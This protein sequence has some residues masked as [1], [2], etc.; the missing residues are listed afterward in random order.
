MVIHSRTGRRTITYQTW[1]QGRDRALVEYLD[2]P[3]ER[4]KKMLKLA[5]KI[6]TYTPEPNDRIISIAGHLLRQSVMAPTSR[7]R[8]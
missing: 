2:P 7:T 8:T 6:W 1:I 5:D 3:R 4:G